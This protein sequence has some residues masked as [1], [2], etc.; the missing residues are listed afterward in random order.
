METDGYIIKKA[1]YH[2]YKAPGQERFTGGPSLGTEYA[3]E[4]IKERIAGL[5]RKPKRRGISV[6]DDKKIN[7]IIDIKNSV[8]A[9]QNAGYEHWAKMYNLKEAAKT[10][11]FLSDNNIL[12]YEQLSAKISE[13]QTLFDD[14]AATLKGAEKRIADLSLLIKN[15]ENFKRTYGAYKAHRQANGKDKEQV[16]RDNESALIVHE[17]ARNALREVGAIGSKQSGKLPDVA[18]LKRER[19]KL[20]A[21]KSVLYEQYSGLKKQVAEYGKI[22]TNIDQILG[23]NKPEEQRDNARQM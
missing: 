1:K 19:D 12:A 17:A 16:Y 23:M 14:T 18:A 5:V 2:S 15:T 9:Q 21:E 22:K 3:D 7:L 6:A 20:T 10:V 4:R 13:I 11:A 8:K